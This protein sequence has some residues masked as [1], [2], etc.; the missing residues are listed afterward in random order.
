MSHQNIEIFLFKDTECNDSRRYYNRSCVA[1]SCGRHSN[2]LGLAGI[3][4]ASWTFSNFWFIRSDVHE[5]Y[6]TK[7]YAITD[8]H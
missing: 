8:F 7:L 2:I 5:R 6:A 3:D 4:D 1:A